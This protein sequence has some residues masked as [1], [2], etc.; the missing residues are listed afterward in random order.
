[1]NDNEVRQLAAQLDAAQAILDEIRVTCGCMTLGP[2]RNEP[3]R[4]IEN[5]LATAQ[6]ALLARQSRSDFVGNPELFGE[7][8]WDM[9]LDLFI[10][11]TREEEITVKSACVHAITPKPTAI[12]WLG[13]LESN[14]LITIRVDPN[15]KERQLIHLTPVGYEGMLRYLESIFQ[16]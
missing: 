14:G 5:A 4:R 11:Q 12:R 16:R 1:V 8:A 10:R 7:P 3:L 2:P 9:L 13:V 15:D 6:E